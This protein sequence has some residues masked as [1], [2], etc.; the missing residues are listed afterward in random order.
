MVAGGEDVIGGRAEAGHHQRLAA[1]GQQLA[2]RRPAVE[3]A[4]M[5]GAAHF[6]SPATQVLRPSR[7]WESSTAT[8]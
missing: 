2:H 1:L 7:R 5:G 4:D 3:A 6:S 8:A